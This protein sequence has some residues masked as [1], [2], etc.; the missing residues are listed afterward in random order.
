M[1]CHICNVVLEPEEVL[2]D[3]EGKWEP[4]HSC[5]S[6]DDSEDNWVG[7]LSERDEEILEGEVS[8]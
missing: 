8:V 3:T 5:S 1:R 6:W 4:C 7:E 2:Q